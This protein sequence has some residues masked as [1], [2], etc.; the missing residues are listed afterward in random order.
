MNYGDFQ[1]LFT[2]WL[3][4][5]DLDQPTVQL[6]IDRAMARVNREAR[7]TGMERTYTPPADQPDGTW[8]NIPI[9]TDFIAMEYFMADDHV[10]D[11]STLAQVLR[12]P[13]VAGRPHG[14]ARQGGFWQLRPRATKNVT[15]IYYGQFDPLVDPTDT[16]ILINA[17]PEVL[18]WATLSYAGDFFKMEETQT[19]EQRYQDELSKLQ[20]QSQDADFF[21][22]PQGVAP[23]HA[24]ADGYSSYPDW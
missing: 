13:N 1:S 3:N 7:L 16:N 19:W 9:P 2:N 11:P 5:S 17:A 20:Q 4:R 8:T 10:I 24:G 15:I 23:A 14:F 18:L 12:M 6:L 22:S 21:A